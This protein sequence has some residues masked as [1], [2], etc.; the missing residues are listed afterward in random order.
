MKLF[1]VSDDMN[2]FLR[3]IAFLNA[4][5]GESF[6]S[7]GYQFFLIGFVDLANSRDAELF[8]MNYAF[9]I[10]GPYAMTD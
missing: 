4:D 2:D 5:L 9:R 3:Y 8:A 1:I 10:L 6:P 7:F